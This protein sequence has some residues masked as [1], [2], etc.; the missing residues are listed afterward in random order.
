MDQS[1]FG[2]LGT[3]YCVYFYYLSVFGLALMILT[4]ISNLWIGIS[5]K[6]GFRHYLQMVSAALIYFIFYFQNRLLYTMCQK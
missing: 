4:I 5:R 1:I 3:E 2:P 6:L